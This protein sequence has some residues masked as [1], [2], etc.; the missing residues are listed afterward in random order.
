[1][2]DTDGNIDKR[3]PQESGASGLFVNIEGENEKRHS[4]STRNGQHILLF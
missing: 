2:S 4:V 3:Y 1:M